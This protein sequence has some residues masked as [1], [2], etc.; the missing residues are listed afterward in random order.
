MTTGGTL[1]D[2]RGRWYRQ[3]EIPGILLRLNDGVLVLS[4]EYSGATGCVISIEALEPEP[5]Y[6]VELGD[7]R[8]DLIVRQS[9]LRHLA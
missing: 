7:G 1:A 5:S 6:L 4:E 8:G 3:E 9:N 2:V